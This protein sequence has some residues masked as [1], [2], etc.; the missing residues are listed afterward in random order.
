MQINNRRHVIHLIA[1][2]RPSDLNCRHLDTHARLH[3]LYLAF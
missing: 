3:L 1:F 2:F